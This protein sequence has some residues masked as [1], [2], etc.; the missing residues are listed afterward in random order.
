LIKKGEE[1]FVKVRVKEDFSR[2]K[3]ILRGG[4]GI[5]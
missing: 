5:L 4:K 3:E 2:V 1:E